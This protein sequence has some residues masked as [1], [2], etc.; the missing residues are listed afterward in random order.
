M[1]SANMHRCG[2]SLYAPSGYAKRHI[3]AAIAAVTNIMPPAKA[4]FARI[5]RYVSLCAARSGEKY[6]AP[7]PTS[8]GRMNTPYTAN[9]TAPVQ[10]VTSS[11]DASHDPAARRIPPPVRYAASGVQNATMHI[12]AAMMPAAV[13]VMMF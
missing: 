4:V 1:Q 9:I 7:R 5:F 6:S 13:R 3:I 12:S 8:A 2:I 11:P 10:H